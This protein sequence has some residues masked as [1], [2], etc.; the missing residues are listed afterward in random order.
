MK[1]SNLLLICL[2]SFLFIAM[3]G[4]NYSLKSEYEKIDLSDRFSGYSRHLL[5]PFKH[6]RLTGQPFGSIQIQPGKNF[7]IRKEKRD[8]LGQLMI[9]EWQQRGDTLI[10]NQQM[11]AGTR[12]I[13]YTPG[14]YVFRRPH[15]YI[16]APEVSSLRS[17]GIASMVSN[18]SSGKFFIEQIGKAVLLRDNRFDEVVIAAAQ[19]SYVGIDGRNRLGSTTV[20][21]RDSSELAIEKDIVGKLILRAD[22]ATT[23][24]LPGSL[25]KKNLNF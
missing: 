25:L 23:L 6:I 24:E 9:L 16:I 1:T 3:V 2:L 20:V 18:W 17:R 7:E 11:E 10:V 4:V 5:K 19:N 21:L 14:G 22:N 8:Q 12:E 15:L 13:P